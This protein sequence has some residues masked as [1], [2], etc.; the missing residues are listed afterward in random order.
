MIR[1]ESDTVSSDMKLSFKLLK[2]IANS[3][4]FSGMGA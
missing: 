2:Y 1:Q 4:L 3:E